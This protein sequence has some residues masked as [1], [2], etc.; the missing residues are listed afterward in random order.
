M[1]R[2]EIETKLKRSAKDIFFISA[3]TGEGTKELLKLLETEVIGNKKDL[4]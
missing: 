3:A 1:I 2:K 4:A